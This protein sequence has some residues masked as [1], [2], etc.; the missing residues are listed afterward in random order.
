MSSWPK[1]QCEP[2]KRIMEM[3]PMDISTK[4][5][6]QPIQWTWWQIQTW[7]TICLSSKFTELSTWSCFKQSETSSKV[8]SQPKFPS[9]WVTNSSRC[10]SKVLQWLHLI[11]LTFHQ[12]AGQSFW[13]MD[14]MVFLVLS[15]RTLK[16]LK[17]WKWW[18]VA[19]VWCN[20]IA[21][22]QRI[23]RIF[24]KTRKMHMTC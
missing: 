20:K 19:L 12:W 17:K 23:L 6:L 22:S 21:C 8:S 14:L 18:P 16:L 3:Q 2:V 13:F 10:Y 24:S 15:Y 7:W 9:L 1:A 4:K 5:L 11:Q